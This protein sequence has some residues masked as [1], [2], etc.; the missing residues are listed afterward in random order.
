M[1]CLKN[2]IFPMIMRQFRV[3]FITIRIFLKIC[4]FPFKNLE[5]KGHTLTDLDIPILSTSFPGG[6]W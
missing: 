4:F 1:R 6:Q 3:L 5:L 2:V